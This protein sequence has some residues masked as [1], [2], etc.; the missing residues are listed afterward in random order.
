MCGEGIVFIY[1]IIFINVKQ[2]IR[3]TCKINMVL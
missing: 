2:N 3:Q 1:A